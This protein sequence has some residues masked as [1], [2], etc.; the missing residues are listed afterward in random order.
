MYYCLPGKE[1]HCQALWRERKA[2]SSHGY[3]ARCCYA[4]HIVTVTVCAGGLKTL[5][6][7][8]SDLYLYIP[9]CLQEIGFIVVVFFFTNLSCVLQVGRFGSSHPFTAMV[10]NL[11]DVD[12]DDAFS[13]IPYEKGFL[14][15]FYLETLVGSAKGM[16]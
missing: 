11:K 7:A 1:N 12:P 15:L 13:T 16:I 4:F 2:P 5:S 9:T 10:P 14:L 3:D 8:V 6:D